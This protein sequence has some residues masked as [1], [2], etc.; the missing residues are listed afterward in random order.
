VAQTAQT[1]PAPVLLL[2]RSEVRALLRWPELIEAAEQA[3][4]TLATSEGAV[5]QAGQLHVPGAALHLKSG[6]LPE[7]PMLSVKANMRPDAGR[8]AGVILAFDPVGYTLR[9]VLDSADIT[10][11][12]TAA[13]AAVAARHLS[14]PGRRSVAVI[15]AGP[16]ARQSLAALRHV[17]DVNDVRL[18]SRNREHAEQAAAQLSAQQSGPVSVC[19]APGEAAAGADIVITATPSREPLLHAG[20][21]APGALVLAMGADTRGKRELGAGVLDDAVVVADVLADA[22]SVG[23]CAYLPDPAARSRCAELGQLL[24]GQRA[25]PAGTG[26]IVFDSVGSAVVDA[27]ATA[28]VLTLA[29]AQNAG[30]PFAFGA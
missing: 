23:E 2:T 25:L 12:R 11:M 4:I 7:P 14:R 21:L 6:A 29:E 1:V 16:V 8:S 27:A 9:A 3:L 18:W 30:R 19:A 15:G 26:R 5:V 22:F 13:I 10:A 20:S 28:L 24:A 17:L